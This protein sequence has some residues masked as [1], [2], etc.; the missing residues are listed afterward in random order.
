M[1]TVANYENRKYNQ[2]ILI[3]TLTDCTTRKQTFTAHG[4]LSAKRTATKKA[5]CPKTSILALVACAFREDKVA[6]AYREDGKWN[7]MDESA[8]N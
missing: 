5:C 8:T 2:W 4:L 3:E 6:V 1:N 7:E